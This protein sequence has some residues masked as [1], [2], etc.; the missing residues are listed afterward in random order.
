MRRVPRSLSAHP[1]H[2]LR[3]ERVLG[4]LAC[5]LPTFVFGCLGASNYE[6]C[7]GLRPCSREVCAF[8]PEMPGEQHMR[9][10]VLVHQ[11]QSDARLLFSRCLQV[12]P[13]SLSQQEH[14]RHPLVG[15]TTFD[16]LVALGAA[17]ADVV[18]RMAEIRTS[19]RRTTDVTDNVQATLAFNRV[20]DFVAIACPA[21]AERLQLPQGNSRLDPRHLSA[22]AHKM[23]AASK[24]SATVTAA[25]VLEVASLCGMVRFLLCTCT[26]NT[27]SVFLNPQ[28]RAPALGGSHCDDDAYAV[29][30]FSPLGRSLRIRV[31]MRLAQGRNHFRHPRRVSVRLR[32]TW[33]PVRWLP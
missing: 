16:A 12:P 11:G 25:V 15:R 21:F 24:T 5:G 33:M 6:L 28:R 27:T 23:L 10:V 9:C 4:L 3:C 7:P 19:Q 2:V 14:C 20:V 8:L 18:K 31:Q 1:P 13:S 17:D 30:R 32:P 22:A 29:A 26:P